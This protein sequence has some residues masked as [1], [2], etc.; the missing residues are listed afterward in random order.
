MR[1]AGQAR[2]GGYYRP[3]LLIEEGSSMPLRHTIEVIHGQAV[4]RSNG[5]DPSPVGGRRE[6][7]AGWS[8]ASKITAWRKAKAAARARET[9]YTRRYL[10]G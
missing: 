2:G 3:P 6:A 7:R 10:D 5:N 9:E 8:K 1:Y 4:Q